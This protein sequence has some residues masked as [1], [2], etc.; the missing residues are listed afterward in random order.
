MKTLT[1]TPTDNPSTNIHGNQQIIYDINTQ[2][3]E[4]DKWMLIANTLKVKLNSQ[5][6][7]NPSWLVTT[8]KATLKTPINKFEKPIFSF[9]RTHEVAVRNRKYSRN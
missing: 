4:L 8:I 1:Y 9:K 2:R 6:S 3:K 7:T 5:Q